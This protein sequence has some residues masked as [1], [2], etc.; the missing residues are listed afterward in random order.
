MMFFTHAYFV[1]E[2]S[3]PAIGNICIGMAAKRAIGE[4]NRNKF[5]LFFHSTVTNN[6]SRMGCHEN[7]F[8]FQLLLDAKIVGMSALLL[9]AVSGTWWESRIALAAN[10][11]VAV[12]LLSQHAQRGLDDATAQTKHQMKSALLLNVVIRQ[13]ASIL[14]LFACEDKTLLIR[15]DSFFV[16]DLCFHI[17]DSVAGF[18]L[19]SNGFTGE[20]FDEDLHRCEDIPLSKKITFAYLNIGYFWVSTPLL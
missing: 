13:S 18:H 11:F 1:C 17:F 9:A 20:R 3:Q 2:R 14:Q 12:V 6:K 15:W 8:L 16:L 4:S 5:H 10:L 7:F 19:Q